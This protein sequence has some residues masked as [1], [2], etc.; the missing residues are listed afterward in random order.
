MLEAAPLRFVVAR[1]YLRVTRN[2]IKSTIRAGSLV[3]ADSAAVREAPDE[4][5]TPCRYVFHLERIARRYPVKIRRGLAADAVSRRL[6]DL[7]GARPLQQ[8]GVLRARHLFHGRP[9]RM[10]SRIAR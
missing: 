3:R 4:F 9:R 7:P 5:F 1:R 6:P 2:E 8:R 10:A